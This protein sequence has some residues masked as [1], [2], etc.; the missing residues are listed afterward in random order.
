MRRVVIQAH[1]GPEQLVLASSGEEPRPGPGQ[2]LVDVE[3]AGLNYL[4]VYQRKGG[5][6]HPV[7]VPF[8]P[9]LEGI[10]RVKRVGDKVESEPFAPSEGMRVAWI[11]VPGSYAEQVLVPASRA[12]VIPDSLT[13]AEGLLFQ[14]LT[15][16]YLATEYRDV[17]PGDR[18]LVHAAAGGVGHLLVQWLKHL[19][20]WV[21]GTTSS[22]EKAASVR[23]LGADAVIN[24][25]R[26]YD[27]LDELLSLTHGR[28]VDLAFDSV[29]AATFEATIASLA[30]GGT[31]VACGMASGPATAVD[32]GLLTAKSLRIAGGNVFAYTADP[33]ELRQ[34]AAKVVEGLTG[35]WLRI[36]DSTAYGLAQAS[37]AHRAIEARGTRGKLYLVP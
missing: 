2:L 33:A 15:A 32:P 14:P 8:T 28:G 17:Q 5:G 1:G 3:V 19:G 24:Y 16:Q 18:V 7:P 11:D 9:G 22:E 27:F 34:R 37:D 6:L 25:G 21:V 10:G 35:G 26:N 20:A 13:L 4:D 31:A 30:R 36:G 12:I 23:A 29:G